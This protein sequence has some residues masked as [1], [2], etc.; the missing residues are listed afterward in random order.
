MRLLT[1]NDDESQGT[2]YNLT[3]VNKWTEVE[4]LKESINLETTM[5]SHSQ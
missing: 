4:H 3:N 2:E 1:N 5:F